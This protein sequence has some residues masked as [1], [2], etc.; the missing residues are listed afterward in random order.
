M[1]FWKKNDGLTLV[2]LMISIAIGS[3]I[4]LT[5]SSVLLLGLRIHHK[6]TETV[7]Q[8]YTARTVITLL[9]NLAAEGSFDGVKR[10]ANGSWKIG[11]KVKRNDEQQIKNDIGEATINVVELE[12]VVLSY[13]AI[14]QAVYV[15]DFTDN[16]TPIL[17]QIIASYIVFNDRVLTI[18]IQDYDQ[19]YT[20]AI[21]CRLAEI[22]SGQ[23]FKEEFSSD[24][25]STTGERAIFISKLASQLDTYGGLIKDSTDGFKFFSEWYVGS[26][27]YEGFREYGWNADTPWCAC[28]VSWGLVTATKLA[29]QGDTDR[30]FAN[31]DN[32]MDYFKK[33]NPDGWNPKNEDPKPGDLIFFDMTKQTEDDPTHMGVVLE[34]LSVDGTK[35]VKTIEGNSADMVAIREYAINDSRILGYGDPW[36]AAPQGG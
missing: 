18:S 31:V 20:S 36:A 3:M 12:N 33:E 22:D 30:W 16:Q 10:E 28:F 13:D 24:D 19:T 9:E 14:T 2:E 17:E 1:K 15:G 5:T 21:Y 6:T 11:K 35:Y 27:N 8:Q 23:K 7:T 25:V 34:V 4:L 29:H 26:I 32:F